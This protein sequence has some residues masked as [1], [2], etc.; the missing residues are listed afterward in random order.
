ML[1][2]H[3]SVANAKNKMTQVNALLEQYELPATPLNYYVFYHY[4][5]DRKSALAHAISHAINNAGIDSVVVE[6]IYMEYCRDNS[7]QA[8]T[9]EFDSLFTHLDQSRRQSEQHFNQYF[10][11]LNSCQAKLT[12]QDL[13]QTQ[14]ALQ[15]LSERTLAIKSYHRQLAALMARFAQKFQGLKQQLRALKHKN[16]V[17]TLTGVYHRHF[18]DQQTANWIEQN[19]A[20]SLLIIDIKNFTQISA[21]YGEANA[22]LLLEKVA[23][24]M[25][26]YVKESGYCARTGV[27]QFAAVLADTDPHTLNMLAEKVASAINKIRF[28]H[29]RSKTPLPGIEFTYSTCSRTDETDLSALLTKHQ[30]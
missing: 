8:L 16:S 24:K 28:V 12:S 1:M 19:K 3:D 10:D 18:L 22:N 7:A 15:S 26:I 13:A 4:V 9:Q 11:E 17:D 23:A 30:R 20:V 14:R 21:S 5:S 27:Y 2:F 6:Q 29:A 25:A